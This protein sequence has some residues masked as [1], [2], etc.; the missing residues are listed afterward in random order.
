[1]TAWRVDGSPFAYR[2]PRDLG[3]GWAEVCARGDDHWHAVEW[4]DVHEIDDDDVCTCGDLGCA[5]G[6]A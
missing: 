4:T 3:D 1:M 6:A 2:V 5:W